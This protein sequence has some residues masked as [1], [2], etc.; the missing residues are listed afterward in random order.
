MMWAVMIIMAVMGRGRIEEGLRPVSNGLGRRD[1]ETCDVSLCTIGSNCKALHA[2]GAE[3]GGEERG[4]CLTSRG[5]YLTSQ[6]Q[7]V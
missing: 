2:R 3:K 5:L 6:R 4:V 7:T 1:R